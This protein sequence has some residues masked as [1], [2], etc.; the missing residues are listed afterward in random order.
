MDVKQK[1]KDLEF[2]TKH[3]AI[4]PEGQL[5]TDGSFGGVKK[6]NYGS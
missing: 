6:K 3:F 2:N 5:L 1:N 4:V